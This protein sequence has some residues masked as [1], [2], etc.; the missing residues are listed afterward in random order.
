MPVNQTSRLLVNTLGGERC[1][2]PLE[3]LRREDRVAGLTGRPWTTVDGC[4]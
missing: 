1:G 3:I 2:I 4:G